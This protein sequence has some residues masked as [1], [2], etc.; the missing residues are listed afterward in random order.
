[1]TDKDKTR[2]ASAHLFATV[3]DRLETVLRKPDEF[4]PDLFAIDLLQCVNQ[5]SF[6]VGQPYVRLSDIEAEVQKRQPQRDLMDEIRIGQKCKMRNYPPVIQSIL[7]D[8]GIG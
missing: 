8:N 2:V 7:R 6:C 4:D 3:C 5:F 1:M